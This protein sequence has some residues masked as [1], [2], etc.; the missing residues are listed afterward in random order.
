MTPAREIKELSA[1]SNSFRV[2][3][4]HTPGPWDCKLTVDGEYIPI[5]KK[6]KL[7][8]EGSIQGM[9][10]SYSTALTERTTRHD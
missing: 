8:L 4:E 2:R 1:K 7:L 3:P 5:T 9:P 10:N 6:D